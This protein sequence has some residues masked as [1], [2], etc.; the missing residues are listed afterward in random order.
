MKSFKAVTTVCGLA[1]AGALFA[2][3]AKA[4]VWDQ[5]TI[6]TFS[7]PV[8]ILGVHLKGGSILPTGTYFFKILD[9]NLTVKIMAYPPQQT[10]HFALR[11][12]ERDIS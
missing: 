10:R 9:S 7:S 4:D 2:P 6:V 8:E 1:L 5:K 12:S 3:P 11:C